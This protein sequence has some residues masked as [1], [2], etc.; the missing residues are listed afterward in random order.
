MPK[1]RRQGPRGP[2]PEIWREMAEILG[3]ELE[4]ML[5][6][7]R[8]TSPVHGLVFAAEYAAALKLTYGDT[9]GAGLLAASLRN[10]VLG[11]D[12]KD[13]F[14][15]IDAVEKIAVPKTVD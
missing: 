14:F 15:D 7:L 2:T 3:R 8:D 1:R 12:P 11:L 5:R 13:L 4:P 10:P 9:S 6:R